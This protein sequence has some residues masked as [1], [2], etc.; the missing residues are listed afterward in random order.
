MKPAIPI[1]RDTLIDALTVM[2]EIVLAL[3]QVRLWTASGLQD[4][5]LRLQLPR[6]STQPRTN[7]TAVWWRRIWRSLM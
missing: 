4:H 2:A 1:N 3:P 5:P 6:S 7:T